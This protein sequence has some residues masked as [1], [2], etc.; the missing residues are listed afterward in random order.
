MNVITGLALRNI[1]SKAVEDGGTVP[2]VVMTITL[3]NETSQA[4]LPVVVDMELSPQ[5]IENLIVALSNAYEKS[6]IPP[7]GILT[8][9]SSIITDPTQ[10][11]H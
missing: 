5:E 9:G 1:Y 2:S 6:Q 4:S 8:T 11:Y 10:P 3:R 7:S